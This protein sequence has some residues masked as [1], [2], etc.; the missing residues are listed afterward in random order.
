VPGDPGFSAAV[1][2]GP[3][4]ASGGYVDLGHGVSANDL[5]PAVPAHFAGFGDA[6]SG[7]Q[8]SATTRRTYDTWSSQYESNGRDEDGDGVVDDW[9]NGLDDD[10]N[11]Q[12]DDAG[13]RETVPPYAFPLRGL[14]VRIRCYEPTSRQ[15][16]QITVRHTFA[17][18]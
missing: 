8:G 7:L 17:P 12:I 10:G 2:P 11:G 9:F 4:V 18:H 13:E 1:G 16:R 3:P 6:R 5:L 15:V 14:E